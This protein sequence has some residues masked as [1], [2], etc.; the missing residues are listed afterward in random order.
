MKKKLKINKLNRNIKYV[1]FFLWVFLKYRN[2][3]SGVCLKVI[4]LS[5]E[6]IDKNK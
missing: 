3:L 1:H 2:K 4:Q 5:L 6:N